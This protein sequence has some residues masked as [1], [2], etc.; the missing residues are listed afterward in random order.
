VSLERARNDGGDRM[1]A[2]LNRALAVADVVVQGQRLTQDPALGS[3]PAVAAFNGFL[4]SV[5]AEVAPAI[6]ACIS[7]H[8]MRDF[9]GDVNAAAF[10]PPVATT[11]P[12]GSHEIWRDSDGSWLVRSA[13]VSSPLA[14]AGKPIHTDGVVLYTLTHR[15]VPSNEGGDPRIELSDSNVVLAF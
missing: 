8:A 11:N 15:I 7:S 2:A 6:A 3:A 14:Q 5:P 1:P 4:D 12:R 13:H 10:D 9:V